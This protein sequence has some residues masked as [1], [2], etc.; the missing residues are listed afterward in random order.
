MVQQSDLSPMAF[1][2]LEGARRLKA[3]APWRHG[4][5]DLQDAASQAVCD[6]ISVPNGPILDYCAGGGGKSLALAARGARVFA[7][8]ASVDRMRDIPDRAERAGLNVRILAT[9]E[10]SRH[11]PFDLV[12]ADVP[13]SGSGAWRRQPEAKWRLTPETLETLEKTQRQILDTCADLTRP[14]G[15]LAYITCSL[16]QRENDAQISAFQARRTDFELIHRRQLTPQDGGD[17]FFLAC[18]RRSAAT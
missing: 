13:C 5:I 10:I 8:D 6:D 12:V 1:E 15:S 3:T 17:G 7:H 11:A 14:K 16:L 4:W 2:V 9:S 18:L